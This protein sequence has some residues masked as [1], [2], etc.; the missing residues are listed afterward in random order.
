MLIFEFD[1]ETHNNDG[2]LKPRPMYWL[3]CTSVIGT[4]QEHEDEIF[5]QLTCEETGLVNG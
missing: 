2:T 5:E 1:Y 4:D 3:G